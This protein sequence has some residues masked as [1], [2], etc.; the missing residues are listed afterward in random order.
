MDQPKTRFASFKSKSEGEVGNGH[1]KKTGAVF[2]T[3]REGVGSRSQ[4][5]HAEGHCM[6][7][8]TS[9]SVLSKKPKK[10]AGGKLQGS[11]S[12]IGGVSGGLQYKGTQGEGREKCNTCE[13]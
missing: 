8:T 6:N 12:K 2:Q 5:L 4:E 10:Q 3:G 1:R 9:K 7:D 13:V 11:L